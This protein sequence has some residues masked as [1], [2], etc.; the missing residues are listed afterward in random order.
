MSQEV[1]MSQQTQKL[2]LNALIALVVG[3]MIG[4]GIFSLPQNIAE[5]AAGG[6]VLIGWA[7]TAVGMLAL[8]FVFQTRANRKPE[9]DSGAYASPKAGGGDHTGS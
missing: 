4:G 9:L 7:I 3:S 8:A 6:A 5:R 2:R 1:A